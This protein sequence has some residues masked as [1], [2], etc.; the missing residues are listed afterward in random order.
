[1]SRPTR[2]WSQSWS[3]S[4]VP[5]NAVL[6]NIIGSVYEFKAWM[7]R[8]FPLSPSVRNSPTIPYAPLPWRNARWTAMIRH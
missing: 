2:M 4:G 8:V 3:W 6:G 1:M 5:D 7:S